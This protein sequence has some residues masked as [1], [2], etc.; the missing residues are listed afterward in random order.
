LYEIKK[1]RG[2]RGHSPR[3]AAEP[4]MMMM[5]VIIIIIIIIM[6][7]IMIIIIIILIINLIHVSCPACD[8]NNMNCVRVVSAPE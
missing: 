2:R 5:M 8:A 3:W 4:E 7:M 6:M 1:V